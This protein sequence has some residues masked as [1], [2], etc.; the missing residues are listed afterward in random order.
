MEKGELNFPFFAFPL[1]FN[2]FTF[3]LLTFAFRLSPFACI[4][5]HK[6]PPS[7]PSP[8][9]EGAAGKRERGL[10]EKGKLNFPFFAFPLLFN[11]FTFRLSPFIC[12]FAFR[13]LFVP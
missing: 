9:G 1:L 3:R 10:M 5:K 12:P 11:A 6:Q 7:Q 4:K 2:A 13:L 8:T